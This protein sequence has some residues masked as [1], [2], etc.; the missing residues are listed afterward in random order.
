MMDSLKNGDLIG[1]TRNMD[2][3][4]QTVTIK[5]YP[6]ITEI[7]NKMLEHNALTSLM[8]GSGPTVFGIYKDKASADKAYS[9]FKKHPKYGEQVFLTKPYYPD[10]Q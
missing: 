8:S 5:N 2:N 10:K 6:I 1:L 3:I 9:Y 4:L 7:K